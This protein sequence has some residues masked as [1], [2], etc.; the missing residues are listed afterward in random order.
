MSRNCDCQPRILLVD[1]NEFNLMP[2]RILILKMFSIQAELAFNGQTAVEMF[3]EHFE[4]GCNCSK[5]GFIFI[6]MDL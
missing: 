3:K 6:F 4:K 1:D 5:R 2:L